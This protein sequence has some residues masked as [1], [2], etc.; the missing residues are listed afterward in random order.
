M[1]AVRPR[2][3]VSSVVECSREMREEARLGIEDA[4]AEPVLVEDLPSLDETPR[5]ACLDGVASCDAVVSI[6]GAR[7]GWVTPSGKLAVEEEAEHA[8]RLGLPLLV[9]LQDADRDEAAEGIG[10]RLEEWVDGRLRTVFATPQDLRKVVRQGVERVTSTV[11]FPVR[12]AIQLNEL[13]RE[14]PDNTDD[15]ILRVVAGPEGDE[16]LVD[17]A[18][19]QSDELR[20]ELYKVGHRQST[21]F[22]SYSE[23]KEH[24]LTDDR[25]VIR[26]TSD[27]RGEGPVE[28]AALRLCEDGTLAV[29]TNVT[30][31]VH[32]DHDSYG[33][34]LDSHVLAGEDVEAG[35]K[36]CFAFAGA[37]Y[38][39]LTR[40]GDTG[41]SC[42]KRPSWGSAT[43]SFS[44]TPSRARHSQW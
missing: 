41:D 38:E 25:L 8:R 33:L 24:E 9:F 42:T 35:F 14:T 31:R 2:V 5:N 3:F 27:R 17:P 30:G 10:R 37:V 40:R 15:V 29:E 18:R 11:R 1:S 16:E 39:S 6:V 4:G 44:G 28:Y 26:Q 32:R 23:A 19:L 13:G 12:D 36:R 43:E 21:G 34:G 20:H 22:W 7:G